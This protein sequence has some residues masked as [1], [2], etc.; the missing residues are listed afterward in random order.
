[1][2]C[3]KCCATAC[4]LFLAAG[5]ARAAI[6]VNE[7]AYDDAGTDNREYVELYNSGAAP[8]DISGWM[9]TGRDPTSINLS[10]A[11][12][13]ATTLAPG[14]F[15]VV[16]NSAVANVNLV[17]ASD[18]LENDIESVELRDSGGALVDAL[19]YEA[20]KGVTG[21]L[22]GSG[23]PAET[24]P[25]YFSNA[26]TG[27][28]LTGSTTTSVGRFVDGRDT[29]NNGRDFGMRPSTPGASNNTG[30]MTAYAPPNPV[31]Q[32][33]GSSVAGLIGTFVDARY[34]DPTVADTNNP[35][36]IP[37]APTSGNR[38]IV[39]WDPSGG[40]NGVTSQKVFDSTQMGFSILA[41]L[42]TSDQPQN[43]N[44][45]GVQFL[46][47]E[48][49]IYNVGGGDQLTNLTDLGGNIGIGPS[50]APAADSANGTSGIA[51]VYEKTAVNGNTPA[52]QILYLVDANDG[53][54]SDL[55]GTTP[56]DWTILQTIDISG[57]P[58]SWF[59]LS[60]FVDAAGN[61][62]ATFNGNSYNFTTSTALHSGAFNVGYRENLQI[63]TDGTPDAIMRPP[64][65]TVVPEPTTLVLAVMAFGLA[66]FGRRRDYSEVL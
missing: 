28:D 46:G 40:G 11:I 22:T 16:G 51:W 25:G 12:P 24:G 66:G 31:G 6:I 58:S 50:T 23:L 55:G 19:I 45:S 32:T 61:G 52:T 3:L 1:M 2:K 48:I 4:A 5:I 13:A 64:T 30:F 53:G 15:Y 54:D 17:V 57:L 27:P 29:N 62:V 8:V 36:A 49:T 20:N 38:A 7:V 60:I 42:D 37:A 14:A 65:F 47:S 26:G 35:N 44:G 34:I 10:A 39:A 21:N 59:G 18:F 56:L 43:S 41:Y 63:G 33:V 9:V